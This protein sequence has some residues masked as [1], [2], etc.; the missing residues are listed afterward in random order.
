MIRLNI[1]N[2]TNDLEAVLLGIA[3]SFGGPL[4]IDQC[5]DPTSKKNILEGTFP[6]EKDIVPEIEEFCSILKKYNVQVFRPKEKKGLNQIFAR[7]IAFVIDD[8]IVLPNII[9]DRQEELNHIKFILDQVPNNSILKMPDY[10]R[11]EGGDVIVCNDFLFI[12]FSEKNDFEKYKVSRTNKLGVTFLEK[13]FKN[14]KIKSFELNKSDDDPLRN[15]LHLDCCFQPIGLD[16]AILFDGGFKNKNDV[17]FIIDH[18]K[19]DNII[20]INR[21]EMYEMC[22]NVFSISNNVI[23]SQKKY[24]RLNNVLREKGFIVEE[25]KYSEISKMGGLLRCSTMPLRRKK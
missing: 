8:K 7:D 18:F 10:A 22:A 21:N 23:V 12:G 6:L 1:S 25:L 17:E 24:F 16:K 5:Y 11:V 19:D 2:E 15:A 4:N 13:Q 9:K 3:E 14:K 20:R